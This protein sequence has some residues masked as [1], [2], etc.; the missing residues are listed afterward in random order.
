MTDAIKIFFLDRKTPASPS[1]RK[2]KLWPLGHYF[3]L[4]LLI[5]SCK[6]APKAEP[7]QIQSVLAEHIPQ[8]Q[9]VDLEGRA[10][11]LSDFKGK[12]VLLN[13]WATWCRPCIE[14]MPALGRL[15]LA[16]ANEGYVFLYASDE[17][18]E[19]INAFKKAKGFDLHFI[20][21]NGNLAEQQ[22]N[23]LPATFIYD[24]DGQQVA[25]FDGA[26]AWD[27]PEMIEQLKSL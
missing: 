25:R 16:L 14:E 23:A 6:E 18:L 4:C 8:S 7:Q 19:K 21:F 5:F 17:S 27:S 9:Y 1:P 20:K 24:A 2:P 26:M 3:A 22:I 10:L 13:Y 15:E 11:G 12:R